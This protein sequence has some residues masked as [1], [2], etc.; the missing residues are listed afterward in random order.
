MTSV[1]GLLIN[2]SSIIQYLASLAFGVD[3]LLIP[4]RT[5]ILMK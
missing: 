3:L 4:A 1:L 5:N 2:L